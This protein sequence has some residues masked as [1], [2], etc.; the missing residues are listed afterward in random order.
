MSSAVTPVTKAAIYARVSTLLG[1][2]P[3]IQIQEIQRAATSKGYRIVATYIDRG[4]SGAKERRPQLDQM[5]ADGYRGKFDLVMVAGIDRLARD[6][7]HLLNLIF[8][9]NKHGI[10]IVSLRESI[11]FS[12][13]LGKATLGIL[14]AVAEL[15]RNLIAE[16]IRVALRAKK[17]AAEKSGS[18]WRC[19][20]PTTIT[21]V[22]VAKV[23]QLRQEGRSI[24]QIARDLLISKTSVERCLKAAAKKKDVDP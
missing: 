15:E 2:D 14:G 22:V 20:R 23:L 12:T 13:P 10:S 18:D 5:I 17:I 7:R 9:L 1:Q 19:G 3:Q 21:T 4:I 8:D 16:R 6:M 11:D 24:R